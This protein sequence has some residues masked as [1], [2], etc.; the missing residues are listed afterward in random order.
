MTRNF[1]LW[2]RARPMIGV[3]GVVGA[4][5]FMGGCAVE[6]PSAPSTDFVLSI[7]VA[8]DS[9]R[10]VDIVGNRSDFLQ[11]NEETGGMS[12]RISR[13]V[14]RA[15]VGERLSARPTENVFATP[16]GSFSI[17]G[18]SV[19]SIS[20]ALGDLLGQDIEGGVTL[21]V[22]P[23]TS[24]DVSA[25]VPLESVTSLSIEEG[26][27]EI[28]VANGL[29]LVLEGLRLSLVDLGNGGVE[30]D[31]IDM[32]VV[33][34]NGGSAIGTFSLSG[35]D[36][37]GSLAIAVTGA[38][39]QGTNVTIEGNPSLDIQAQLSDLIVSQALAVIPQQEFSDAQVLAFLDDRIQVSRAVIREGGLV[40]RVTNDIEIIMELELRLDDLRD[41]NGNVNTFLVDQLIPGETREIRFDLNDNE[42]VPENPLEL[43]LSYSV[44]TFPSGDP[45]QIF[46]T[47]ELRVEAIT[48]SLVFE[49]V[50]G[51][52]NRVSLELPT[53]ERSVDFPDGLNNVSIGTTAMDIFVTSAVGFLAD[54]DLLITGTNAFGQSSELVVQERFERGNAANPVSTQR[55][56]APGELTDFLNLLPT[57]IQISSA[58]QIGD[59]QEE[60]VITQA[61]WVSVDSVVLRSSPRLTVTDTTR[62]DDDVRDITFRDSDLRRKILSNFRS[63][64]VITDLENSIPL[65]VGVRLFVGRTPETVYTNP[66]ITIPKPGREPF[67]AIAAPIDAD[68]YSNG[69][70]RVRREI[71]LSAEDVVEFI[72]E[73]DD[74]GR[75]YSG[76]RVTFP[77]TDSEVEVLGT[78]FINIIAG[79][80]V[81]LLLDD[82]LV[83]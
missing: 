41:A 17:P 67:Q 58:V 61:Q 70:E 48:E 11:I 39:A 9:A 37:S 34:A 80:E 53:V 19:P 33:A 69:T 83:E 82:T 68:G 54:V 29:P 49:R 12:L 8:N 62:I 43:R 42:F 47:G 6:P 46:S 4:I 55:S 74:D 78:D 51:R 21:P 73:D 64:R 25:E 79:L 56:V 32:G 60:E 7:P 76:V 36:I 57:Q 72:L 52:L 66:V 30:V 14:G 18:Q 31:A 10:V 63:S 22:V 20:I 71:E 44:R 13:E 45:V 40:L 15:D 50:E 35:K 27:L 23:A 28:A 81:E 26:D 5:C 38:T 3:V 2:R 77:S 59:G 1:N 24:I 16:I 65:G 75:L